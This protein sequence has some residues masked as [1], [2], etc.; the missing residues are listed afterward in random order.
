MV[1]PGEVAHKL[2]RTVSRDFSPEDICKE[3]EG[4]VCS[5]EDRQHNGCCLH[6]QPRGDGVQ[7]TGVPNLGPVDVVSREEHPYPSTISAR[8]NERCGRQGIEI[9]EGSIG[10]ET[11]SINIFGDQRDLWSTGSGPVCIQT[12]QPVPSLLQLA[13]RSICRGNRCLPAGLDK[14]E[15]LYQPPREPDTESADEGTVSGGKHKSSNP[16]VE[17][18]ALVPLLLSMLVDWPRLLPKQDTITESVPIMPQLAMWSISGKDWASRA[19]QARLRTSSSNH[20]GRKPISH[21]IHCLGHGTTG[22][23][24]GVQIHSLLHN[25]VELYSPPLSVLKVLICGWMTFQQVLSTH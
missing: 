20:G 8:D 19:F 23:L 15:R 2:P 24:N 5:I 13:A 17:D 11:G 14:G 1:P 21:M 7:G 3:Q 25:C 12:N 6:Q 10:L 16:S 22:V 18:T 4:H 9:H